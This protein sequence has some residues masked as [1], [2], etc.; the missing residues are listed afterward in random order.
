MERITATQ[1][2]RSMNKYLHRVKLG[3]EIIIRRKNGQE[4]TLVY[5][6]PEEVEEMKTKSTSEQK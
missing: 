1:F 2:C 6:T 3:E 4:Y 5:C